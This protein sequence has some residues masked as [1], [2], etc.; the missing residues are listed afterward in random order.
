[1]NKLYMTFLLTT[2][3]AATFAHEG[4]NQ[5]PGSLKSLH[6]GTVQAGKQINLE[7]I[8]SGT[9]LTI[10]PESH[11]GKD[12]P[13]KDV[14]IEAKASPKKG[15]PYAVKFSPT[16]EG[17]VATVDLAGANRLPVTITTTNQGKVDHFTVQVEE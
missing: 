13:A 12:L 4:H 15:K 10:Y 2:L 11:E 5:A 9:H 14:L 17:F 7:V 3:A 1:M 6:G 16:K 8:I